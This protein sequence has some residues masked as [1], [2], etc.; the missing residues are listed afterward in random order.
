MLNTT[1]VTTGGLSSAQ[2]H[3]T[4]VANAGTFPNAIDQEDPPNNQPPR[5]RNERK[6]AANRGTKKRTKVK[7]RSG[8]V[9]EDEKKKGR[10]RQTADETR[11]DR[12]EASPSDGHATR[13][14]GRSGYSGQKHLTEKPGT[15]E[16]GAWLPPFQSLSVFGLGGPSCRFGLFAPCATG[17]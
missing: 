1:Q 17:N 12:D 10:G 11:R 7:Q 6:D 4:H 15:G 16:V 13:R 3:I 9:K 14:R 8:K 2:Q 5:E